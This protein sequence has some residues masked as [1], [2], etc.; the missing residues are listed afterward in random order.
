MGILCRWAAQEGNLRNAVIACERSLLWSWEALRRLDLTQNQNMIHGYMRLIAIYLSTT[1]EYFNKV[2]AHLHTQDALM[3]YNREAALLTERVFEEIGL[4]ATIGLT[5]YLWGKATN[6]E[7]CVAGAEAVASSLAEFLRSHQISGSPC[8]DGQSIDIALAL[9]FLLLSEQTDAMKAWLRKLVDRLIFGF[10]RGRWFPISTD[11]FDDLVDLELANADA[12]KLTATSWMVPLIGEWMAML[13]DDEGYSR[14]VGLNEVLKETS[15]QVWY[16]D[17][18]TADALYAGPALETGITEAPI[19]LP[20]NGDEMRA[21][22][23][24]IRVESPAKEQMVTSAGR[25]GIGWL[26]FIASRHFRTPPDP[27]FWQQLEMRLPAPNQ[28]DL[29]VSDYDLGKVSP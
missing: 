12:K 22:I 25:A 2:Q 14:L 9:M 1:A 7:Q 13:R 4:L 16:P 26:D 5:H 27:C 3:R 21:R 10:R 24:K 15:F 8:Y 11:S 6:D 17:E 28:P 23:R 19:V 18:K 20:P 29:T